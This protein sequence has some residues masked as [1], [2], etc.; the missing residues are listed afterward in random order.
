MK[1]L[2]Q[3]K[4]DKLNVTGNNNETGKDFVYIWVADGA[5]LKGVQTV[6]NDN[7]DYNFALKNDI[8]ATDVDKYQSIGGNGTAFAG[9][10]DGRGNRIIG[11]NVENKD[12]SQN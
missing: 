11:L 3:I 10:F 12:N 7:P 1:K 9:K 2:Y 6:V 5:Q 8:N 4:L